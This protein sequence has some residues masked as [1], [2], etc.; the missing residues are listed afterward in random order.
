[1]NVQI[2]LLFSKTVIVG[3]SMD[4]GSVLCVFPYFFVLPLAREF[5]MV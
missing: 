1:M 5:E 4:M 2:I 3:Y